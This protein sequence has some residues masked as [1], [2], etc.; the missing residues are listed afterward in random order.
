MQQLPHNGQRRPLLNS[1][2]FLACTDWDICK[3]YLNNRIPAITDFSNF[4]IDKT[5]PVNNKEISQFQ[6]LDN[7]SNITEPEREA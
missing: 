5:V 6:T 7:F 1:H 2:S 3:G 4:C